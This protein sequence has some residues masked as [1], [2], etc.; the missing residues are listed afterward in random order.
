MT[1]EAAIAKAMAF[2]GHVDSDQTQSALERVALDQIRVFTT[3]AE[4]AFA[5]ANAFGRGGEFDLARH[6]LAFRQFQLDPPV[7]RPGFG[8]IGRIDRLV[9]PEP[10]RGQTVRPEVQF[11]HHIAHNRQGACLT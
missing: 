10:V 2:G 5:Q 6:A 7:L 4:A 11:V 9:F 3:P 8:R 1:A